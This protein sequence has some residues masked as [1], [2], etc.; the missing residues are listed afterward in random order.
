M[1][2]HDI[3]TVPPGRSKEYYGDV[4]QAWSPYRPE[5][6]QPLSDYA[7]ELATKC[8]DCPP[9]VT[10]FRGLEASLAASGRPVP[11]SLCLVDAWVAASPSHEEWLRK[12]DAV[13]EPWVS[14]LLPWNS[15]DPETAAAGELRDRL[16]QLLG[17][18]WPACR[19]NASSPPRAFRHFRNS[20]RC[21]P[22]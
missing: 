7:S 14:V 20:V 15:Q 17:R 4:P 16:G 3:S 21:C 2:A 8:L 9:V 6:H 1:L 19:G 22:K 10:S 5:Y 13:E 11:P 12:L 18:A